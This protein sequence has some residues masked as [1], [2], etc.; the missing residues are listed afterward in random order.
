M[1]RLLTSCSNVFF[2]AILN[3]ATK[4]LP[5][6][7]RGCLAPH[8]GRAAATAVPVGFL[9]SG[10]S[11]GITLFAQRDTDYQLLSMAHQLQTS[12]ALPLGA[13]ATGTV[14]A[15][16]A[17]TAFAEQ[18]DI[19]VCGAHLEGQPLNWQ[20]R[21]RSAQLV[22]AT[23]TSASY[24]LYALPDNKRPALIR[25]GNASIDVE[26]WSMPQNTWGSFVQGIAPPLGIG[27]V[28]LADG[29]WL[30]GF[31]CA[32]GVPEGAIDISHHGGWR[33]WLAERT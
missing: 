17:A 29:R 7:T 12:F 9:P 11:W 21:E 25:E 32:D 30:S 5:S 13:G 8:Q 14:P 10:V 24:T 15:A 6:T 33:G 22:E 23:Q 19:V 3:P 18:V 16:P 28:E 2:V 4:A 1:R 27:K 20:L 26:I 31:I